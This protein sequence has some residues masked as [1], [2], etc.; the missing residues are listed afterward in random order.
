MAEFKPNAGTKYPYGFKYRDA[1]IECAEVIGFKF[2]PLAVLKCL[3]GHCNAQNGQ[4]FPSK[5]TLAGLGG[6]GLRTVKRHL[7]TLEDSGLIAVMAYRNGGHG[8][9]TVYKFGLPMHAKPQFNQSDESYSAKLAWLI[10]YRERYGANLST[11][12]ANLSTYS[13]KMAHQ[14]DRNRF[15]KE[16]R[17][18]EAASR[19]PVPNDAGGVC[20][21]EPWNGTEPYSNY[22]GRIKSAERD[23][24]R[25]AEN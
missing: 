17:E 11:Y 23:A 1:V 21:V 6:M 20:T 15:K 4:A 2:G 13:A 24:L 7:R 22:L 12:S 18:T 16:E 19:G 8:C 5:A 25:A 9:A 14:Q 10:D 3:V